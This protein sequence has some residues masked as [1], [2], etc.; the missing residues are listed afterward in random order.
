[1]KKRISAV[2][3]AL[4]MLLTTAYAMEIYADGS[5]LEARSGMC[6][7]AAIAGIGFDQ[8][9]LVLTHAMAHPLSGRFGV[10]H[11]VACALLT[12]PVMAFNAIAAPAWDR[13]PAPSSPLWCC[14]C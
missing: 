1:M 10:P 3:L 12:P 13:S 4:A 5:D 8:V 11:G 2:L 9:G 6:L 14:S 7:A